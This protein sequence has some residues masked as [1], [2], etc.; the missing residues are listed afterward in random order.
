LALAVESSLV[1]VQTLDD[2]I[3]LLEK[4]GLEAVR[5]APAFQ[6]LLSIPGVG[7]VGGVGR[8]LALTILLETGDIRRFPPGSG[9]LPPT[10]EVSKGAVWARST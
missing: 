2:L 3:G 9:T 6:P 8:V 7:G 10:P 4:Q 1:V 5:L